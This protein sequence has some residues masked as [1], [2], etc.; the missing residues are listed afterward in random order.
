MIFLI[1]HFNS[2]FFLK[3]PIHLNKSKRKVRFKKKGKLEKI[4][5][6]CINFYLK[7]VFIQV[8]KI[9]KV[10]VIFVRVNNFEILPFFDG[11][12]NSSPH[13][14]TKKDCVVCTMAPCPVVERPSRRLTHWPLVAQ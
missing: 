2:F 7:V 4:L 6:I 12:F 10:I 8:E 3:I 13:D 1:E 9:D 11:F 14:S 5:Y